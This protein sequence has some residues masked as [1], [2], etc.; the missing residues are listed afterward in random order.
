MGSHV[1]AAAAE[2]HRQADHLVQRVAAGENHERPERRLLELE[3]QLADDQAGSA[4]SQDRGQVGQIPL[5]IAILLGVVGWRREDEPRAR[6]R[7]GRAWFRRGLAGGGHEW[8]P[9]FSR[10]IT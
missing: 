4:D 5:K 10:K 8:C 2:V 1:E 9:L 6:G 7:Y 3:A